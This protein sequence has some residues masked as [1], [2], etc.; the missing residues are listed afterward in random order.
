MSD[1][2]FP[3]DRFRWLVCC[4]IRQSRCTY[5]VFLRVDS[6]RRIRI[7]HRWK[8]SHKS[9]FINI[10]L[11]FRCDRSRFLQACWTSI[12][13]LHDV[14][15]LLHSLHISSCRLSLKRCLPI[16]GVCVAYSVDFFVFISSERFGWWLQFSFSRY[17]SVLQSAFIQLND[18][19]LLRVQL[20]LLSRH[21]AEE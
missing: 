1:W 2:C 8:R 6:D 3:F 11:A 12:H 18:R 21:H 19:S 13:L 17:R 14:V 9:R 15:L 16:L 20:C 4:N 5:V 7:S 10:S